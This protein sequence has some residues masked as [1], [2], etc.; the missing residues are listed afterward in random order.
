MV[1]V[2]SPHRHQVTVN[3]WHKMESIFQPEQHLQL[4]NGEITTMSPI[5]FPHAGSLKYLNNFFTIK[6]AGKA[7]ISIQDPL[8]LNKF[9]EPEPDLM[10]LKP[11]ANFYKHRHPT[12][13]DV[14]LLIE[15]SDSSLYF[16]R[17][18]K[19][20][21]YAQHQISDYW[22]VNLQNNSLEVYRQPKNASYE[23]QQTLVGGEKI[24][25]L[26]FPEITLEIADIF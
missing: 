26:Y 5:G 1:A 6:F 23:L 17:Q 21:L 15:I 10:L 22:I 24:Q 19:L 9:S 3:E 12:A 20:K 8:V 14:L 4:I 25:P 13:S 2:A 7:I 11:E 16:D 18:Q